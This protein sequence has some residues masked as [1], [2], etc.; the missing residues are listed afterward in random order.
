MRTLLY[1]AFAAS[2]AAGLAYELVWS[3]YLALLVGHSAYAQV[4]VIGVL[5]GGM[6]AGALGIGERSRRIRRP[7][8]WYAGAELLLASMG[9]AFHPLFRV[10]TGFAYDVLFPSLNSAVLAGMSKWAL[11]ILLILGQSVLLGTTFP[12]MAAGFLRRFP[13]AAGRSLAGL[14]FANSLG[15]AA[16]VVLAGFVLI[17]HLFLPGTLLAASLLNLSAAGVAALVAATT[18]IRVADAGEVARRTPLTTVSDSGG[19]RGLAVLLLSV[20]FLTAVAS[21]TYEIGWI[22]MLSLVMGSATHSFE[23]MLSAFILGLA[24]GS[25]LIG[26][27]VDGSS[28]PV[29]L[30]GWIQ[31]IMGVAAL[32]TLPVYLASFDV[33]AELTGRIQSSGQGYALFSF[34]R[35]A[36]A[37]AVMLP[38]TV[39]AGM[40]LPLITGT[41]LRAGA[42]EGSIGWVYGVNTLGS[43]VGVAMA[44]LVALPVLGLKGMLVAGATLDMALGVALLA[45]GE[46]GRWRVLR[47]A[48]AAGATMV[49]AAGTALGLRFDRAVL[50]S[51][52]FRYGRVPQEQE[53]PVYF[54]ADGRTASVGVHRSGDLVVL[55]TNGKPDAS[56]TYRWITAAGNPVEPLPIRT[57]D[58]STQ[59]LAALVTLAHV[60]EPRRGIVIGHGSGVS[61]HLLLGHSSLE[62]LVTVEIEPEMIAGARLFYPANRRVYDD[63]RSLFV[64]DDAKSYFALGRPGVDLILSEPSNPWVSGVAGLFTIEFYQRVRSFLSSDGVFAQWIQLYEIT[65]ELVLTVLAAIHEVF[66]AYRCF[67][68]GDTDLLVVAGTRPTLPE[69][70]WSVFGLPTIRDDLRHV[71]PFTE[72]FLDAIRL[73]DRAEI[74]PLIVREASPNSDFRPYL[75]LG[76]DQARALD[77]AA[78][79]IFALATEWFDV[80]AALAGRRK[81]RLDSYSHPPVWGLPPMRAQA[82]SAWLRSAR[83]AG[84][85]PAEIPYGEFGSALGRYRRLAQSLTVPGPPDDWRRWVGEVTA[86]VAALHGGSAG[87][88]DGELLES[89]RDFVNRHEGPVE[90]AAAIDFLAGIAGWGFHRSA[91]AAPALIEALV[92]G[93]RWLDPALVL[94]GSVVSYLKEGNPARAREV[95]ELLAPLSEGPGREFRNALLQAHIQEATERR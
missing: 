31:W 3:R 29:R 95:F 35:Y 27:K 11:A 24:L 21:F 65:D 75:D 20:S 16:G 15:G 42:G 67:L 9:A 68:V 41:L 92:G 72:P 59:T 45:R 37:M 14:Y 12:L 7:L 17:A 53:R 1:L 55:T 74:A 93:D 10:S 52:V 89:S 80:V 56:L 22:R 23:L 91:A 19:P 33:M 87:E 69:P 40:T 28:S 50:T 82:Q 39:L 38:S 6:G 73:F 46:R 36:L 44:G 43:V 78:H 34:A 58:E 51:G 5:L 83:E 25:L 84:G 62:S 63:P 61:G 81:I 85:S 26:P 70:D 88:I 4:L 13:E 86:V 30:L 8:L 2:G 60:S 57:Q 90:A 77:H 64:I 32:A 79:G 76:A 94:D 48:A 18:P 54:Y 49:L 66:P 47:P 71:P